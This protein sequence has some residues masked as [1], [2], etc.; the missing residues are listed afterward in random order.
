MDG[1]SLY[2]LY[3]VEISGKASRQSEQVVLK[4]IISANLFSKSLFETVPS[5]LEMLNSGSRSPSSRAKL[6][7]GKSSRMQAVRDNRLI[8]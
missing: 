2:V 7:A 1:L 6:P 3:K 5:G 8:M 4:K